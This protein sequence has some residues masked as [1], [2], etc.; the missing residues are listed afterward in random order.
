[1]ATKRKAG[2]IA[3]AALFATLS[4]HAS[5]HTSTHVNPTTV[6]AH[7][8]SENIHSIDKILRSAKLNDSS[9]LNAVHNFKID[10]QRN[11]TYL[12]LVKTDTDY[13]YGTE[14][15][16]GG[17]KAK[18]EYFLGFQVYNPHNEPILKLKV[19]DKSKKIVTDKC[20]PACYIPLLYVKS[21]DAVSLSM[22]VESN[23]TTGARFIF[24]EFMDFDR[25]TNPTGFPLPM[26]GT[27]L[28]GRVFSIKQ[29]DHDTQKTHDPK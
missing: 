27:K 28:T 24:L 3:A 18:G 26:I 4:T 11:R 7:Q 15:F 21:G 29:P 10:S 1:M 5:T 20:K 2:M 22:H 14:V 19:Y 25:K 12:Y 13:L 23:N 8:N 16:Y 17:N 9:S 6:T